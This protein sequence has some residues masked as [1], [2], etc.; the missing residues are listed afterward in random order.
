MQKCRTGSGK[1]ARR[2]PPKLPQAGWGRGPRRRPP[3]QNIQKSDEPV[4]NPLS[5][6]R[7]LAVRLT[8][9]PPESRL[10]PIVFAA[11][12]ARPVTLTEQLQTNMRSNRIFSSAAVA[13]G[14]LWAC[15]PVSAQVITT[16][17]LNGTVVNEQGSPVPNA[18]VVVIH[19]PTGSVTS[20]T[21]RTDG[22]FSFRGLRPGGPYTVKASAPGV[23][24][25]QSKDIYLDL[26]RGADVTVRIAPD[27]VA[28]EKYVISASSAD[29]L[30][31]PSQTGSGSAYGREQLANLPAG[32]RSINSL[33]RLDPHI[34][35]NRDP[36]DRAISVNGISN[37][38]NS[39]Q[40]DGVTA[41]DPF[42]LNANNTA[43]ERNVVPMES[44]ES[45]SINTSN[46][47]TRN[48]GFIGASINAVTKS[49]GNQYHGSVYYQYRD[50][51]LVGEKLDGVN[52][53][54]TN[55]KEQT[56]GASLGGPII[57]N[58]LFFYLNYEKVDEDRVAP[59]PIKRVEQATIDQIV[60]AAKSLGFDPGSA[61]PPTAN[62]L[63]DDNILAK[64][65][66]VI[67]ANHRAVFRYNDVKSSRPTFP[68][69]G[70]GISENNF[71]FSSQW[72]QQEVKNTSYIAQLI[73]SWN[74]RLN[75]EISVSK[76]TYHSEPKNSTRQP[77][78]E[79]RNI[80]VPGSS[81]TAY[82]YFGTERSRHANILDTD[83]NTAELYG[84]YVLT[85]HHTL[86]SGI[87]YDTSDVYNLFVQDAYGTYSFN[88]LAE[89]L[90]I[91]ASNNGTKN[92]RTYSYNRVDPSVEA[93]G[94]FSEANAGFFLNDKWRATDSLTIDAGFRVDMA[95]L[96]DAVPFNQKFYD[97]FH[98]RNDYTYDGKTSVQPRLGFNWTVSDAP[99]TVIRGGFGL[100][101]GR[102]PRVWL[103]N[104]YSN[105]G[106]NYT[107]YTAGTNPNGAS[108]TLAPAVSANPD[109]QPTSGSAPA[110]QVSFVDPGYELPSRWK[111]NLAVEREIPLL[112]VKATAE[113]E[114]TF[115]NKD[116][117]YR[118]LNLVPT[119]TSPDGRQLFWSSYNAVTQNQTTGSYSASSGTKLYSSA[120]TNRIIELTNTGGGAT[121]ALSL[122]LERAKSKDGWWWKTS[123]VNTHA[124]EVQFGTSSVAASNWQ[125]RSVFNPGENTVRNS[126]LEVRHK[127]LAIVSKEI[128]V[129]K[130]YPTTISAVY[131]GRSGYPFS[132]VYSNDANGDSVTQNDLLYVP[133]RDG[134]PTVRFG[135]TI[136]GGRVTQTA[137]QARELFYQIVD[138]F[139]LHEGA[140]VSATSERYPWVNQ[141]D[142][143]VKQVVKLPGWHHRIVLGVDVLNVGNLLN[144]KWGLIRG[145][146][147]FFV[148]REGAVQSYYDGATNQYVYTNVSSQL[149][150]N[151]FNP[152]LGRGEPAASRWSVLL[153]AKYEF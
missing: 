45:L 127:F 67:N 21:S 63:K 107:T 44:V 78:V 141:F 90:G 95:V 129:F 58:R 6:R 132:I 85:D 50:Q 3:R 88:N 33:A 116:V 79:I 23:G 93:A 35:Y 143:S 55:F 8:Q 36:F 150:N 34:M 84:S 66:W 51:D 99:R 96:P 89:F 81:N 152:S 14:L 65:D 153:T 113:I 29:R 40:V 80:T 103:S 106:F 75:T 124:T 70:S 54:L 57:K 64:L 69:F 61:E 26:E 49:G 71:S 62:K 139:N 9:P 47:N 42:G 100:F 128:Q 140:A 134:D 144:D 37:R 119:R 19:E 18:S 32:D 135:Q 46:Y 102:M 17:P 48:G 30:F 137:E 77:Q 109:Q 136:S 142:I 31:D 125:N 114:Q 60:A 1:E 91:A 43:A 126:E 52:Y 92:Y 82:A 27:V 22:S 118:N 147:Q 104:S 148:K 59:T 87:Q 111:T 86:E 13:A 11:E 149:A 120:F 5:N 7:R 131:E 72:Y 123:Y 12:P 74:D 98:I 110:A 76:S 101:Y 56:M 41:S 68:N 20:G 121:R 115:V 4:K 97:T 94:T 112:N 133:K 130:G 16:S 117:L 24:E 25:T 2:E 38:F 145:S 15:A 10:T 151:D 28:L 73:S 53:S 138:R 105:T 108:S 83:S 146:N 122:S 39:I